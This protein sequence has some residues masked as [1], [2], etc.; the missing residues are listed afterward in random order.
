MEGY[1]ER[2]A[3]GPK[4]EAREHLDDCLIFPLEH[5]CEENLFW[6]IWEEIV[7]L[8]TDLSL[9]YKTLTRPPSAGHCEECSLIKDLS[10]RT[11]TLRV[12]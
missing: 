8:V 7:E 2:N 12:Y 9:S 4:M 11:R 3:G 6:K 10:Y 5:S 1:S